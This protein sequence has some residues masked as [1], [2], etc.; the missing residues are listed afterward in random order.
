MADVIG[1]QIIFQTLGEANRLKII[2]FIGDK[3]RSVTEI[4]EA[5]GLSQPLVSH[6]LRML[7]EAR[8]METQREGPFVYYRIR[9]QRL[10]EALKV[11]LEIFN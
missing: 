3:E 11:F 6:H 7:R 5:T 2:E 8:I 4:V 10:L 1:L 9:D